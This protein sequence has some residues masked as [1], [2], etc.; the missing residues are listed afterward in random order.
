MS[1]KLIQGTPAQIIIDTAE[2]MADA[3]KKAD[4]KPT[5][6]HVLATIH[7]AMSLMSTG[8]AIGGTMGKMPSFKMVLTMMTRSL[9][10][11]GWT[12]EAAKEFD[13]EFGILVES[14]G[15]KKVSEEGDST[16]QLMLSPPMGGIH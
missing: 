15:G 12:V 11:S 9:H 13:E 2:E 10:P 8:S 7:L 16:S 5:G 3:M 4:I 1:T 6:I 14:L